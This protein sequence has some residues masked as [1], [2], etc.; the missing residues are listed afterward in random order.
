MAKK[1]ILGSGGWKRSLLALA[2]VA[3]GLGGLAF[4]GQEAP[5]AVTT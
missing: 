1:S 2:L 4:A 5:P 3:V